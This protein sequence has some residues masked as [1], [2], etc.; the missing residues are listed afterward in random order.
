M[1][2]G[3]TCLKQVETF[4]VRWNLGKNVIFEL[5]VM[6]WVDCDGGSIVTESLLQ[7]FVVIYVNLLQG[8]QTIRSKSLP[9]H[10][11]H[12]VNNKVFEIL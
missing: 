4:K 1:A 9:M 5:Y 3:D 10:L 7:L 11:K 8:L 12:E 6:Y 2:L